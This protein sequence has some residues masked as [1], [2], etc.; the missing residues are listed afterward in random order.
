MLFIEK[1]GA[2]LNNR[3][4]QTRKCFLILSLIAFNAILNRKLGD[5]ARFLNLIFF[6]DS[7]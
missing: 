3:G 6:V 5:K 2:I 7:Y 4:E 1:R